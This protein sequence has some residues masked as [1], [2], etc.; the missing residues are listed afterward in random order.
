MLLNTVTIFKRIPYPTYNRQYFL[1]SYSCIL[2][3]NPISDAFENE[4]LLDSEGA[5][6][7]MEALCLDFINSEFRDFRGRWKRYDLQQPGWME[8]LLIKWG[9]QVEQPLD[10]AM[11]T[12]VVTLRTLLRSIIAT[13]VDTAPGSTQCI[14]D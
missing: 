6:R 12:Q 14:H 9:L 13:M 5:Q 10:E 8:Q 1:E 4:L 3:I 7:S 11:L 2:H